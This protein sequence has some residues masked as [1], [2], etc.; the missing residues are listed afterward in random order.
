MLALSIRIDK[1]NNYYFIFRRNKR[2]EDTN[3]YIEK[4]SSEPD[5]SDSAIAYDKGRWSPK[6]HEFITVDELS[7]YRRR[8]PSGS[9][10]GIA[11]AQ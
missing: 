6:F 9:Y 4:S 7:F 3:F 8:K 2:S 1:T 10:A 11:P 5:L